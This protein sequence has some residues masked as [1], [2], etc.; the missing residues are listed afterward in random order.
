MSAKPSEKAPSSQPGDRVVEASFL[1]GA[2]NAAQFPPPAICEVAFVGRSNVGKSSLM[3]RLTERQ[4]L[5]RTS[6][7]PGC[8]RQISWFR[9]VS[10][11]K[12]VI[13]LVDLPGYGYAKRSKSERKEWAGLIESYLLERPTLRAVVLL[14][15]IRRGSEDDDLEL[16]KM[17]ADGPRVSRAPLGVIYVATKMDK[18]PL[19]QHK[20][21]L[22]GLK[23]KLGR[24]LLGFSAVSGLGRVPLWRQ[25]RNLAGIGA[26]E[27]SPLAP[28][29]EV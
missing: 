16:I 27:D 10:D 23:Q 19:N 26:F 25:V 7:T 13:D 11:D 24:P 12:A 6:S 22:L 3:N 4:S 9:T 8:T 21:A 29:N 20:P 18:L 2:K 1:A 28:E 15:D 14:V 5:V 17:L